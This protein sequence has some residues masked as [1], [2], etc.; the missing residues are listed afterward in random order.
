[1]GTPFAQVPARFRFDP[2]FNSRNEVVGSIHIARDITDRRAAEDALKAS[3]ANY[4]TLFEHTLVGMEVVDA[5]TMKVV[6]ANHSI[7]R[8]FG[9]KSPQ[10]MVGTEP[11]EYVLP[12][13]MDW[14]VGELTKALADPNDARSGYIEN[15]DGGWPDHMGHRHGYPF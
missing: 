3:E 14:V 1:M 2:L 5:E 15:Q 12:E 6:L 11:L 7:A 10:D 13:D 4:R 9:F 8:M